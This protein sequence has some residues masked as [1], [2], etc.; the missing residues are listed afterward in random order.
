MVS[1]SGQIRPRVSY[2]REHETWQVSSQYGMNHFW[3]G[4]DAQAFARFAALPRT[5]APNFY[6]D[7]W[8]H[9]M[10]ERS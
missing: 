6:G 5:G 9:L 10:E 1:A 7:F 3:Y 8:E 4:S 2:Q